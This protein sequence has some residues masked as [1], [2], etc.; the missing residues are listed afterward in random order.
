MRLLAA[1]AVAFALVQS[2]P[3]VRVTPAV[4]TPRTAFTI[5]FRTAQGTGPQGSVQRRDEIS[6][7]VAVP[8]HG[9]VGS[10]SV[11]AQAAAAGTLL[12][13]V[14][15]PHPGRWCLGTFRGQVNELQTPLCGAGQA[16][17]QYVLLHPIG[18][19]SFTVTRPRAGADTTPP[20]FAGLQRA[21]ACTPG[22]QRPG[23]TT[24]FTL[25]WSAASDARTPS[26]QIVYDVFE[27]TTPGGEDFTTPTWTTAPGVTT[28]R[29]PG[30]ASHGSFYFVVRARDRAGNEDANAV[31]VR[32]VDPCL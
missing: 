6:A 14:A 15:L 32:G 1:S 5:S 18:R 26:T 13:V 11:R 10:V 19:F 9:C 4:G 16:C 27:S 31:E 24:P 22:P 21:V 23:Q 2:G 20:R 29:T 30:L 7:T 3:A 28:Y 25:S 12:H 8:A 17:P